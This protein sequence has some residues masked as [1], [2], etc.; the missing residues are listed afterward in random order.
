VKISTFVYKQYLS[1]SGCSKILWGGIRKQ[2][3]KLMGDPPC[4]M[5]IHGKLLHL[6]LS[7]ALPSYLDELPFYDTLPGRL[8][9]FLYR[10]YGALKCVDVGANIGDSIAAFSSHE[11]EMFLAIEPN[12]NFS[13]YLRRNFGASKN[14]RIVETICSSSNLTDSYEI[15]ELSGTASINRTENG[16]QMLTS[17]LDSIIVDN[18]E[19]LDLNVL[20]IDTDGHDFAVIDG[21]W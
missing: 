11:S 9:D 15:S 21:A 1:S 6:P 20:K 18:P 14:V 8:S 5:N 3:V 2:L 19:F 13:R 4:T 12:P 10:R 17:T 16:T 7:H